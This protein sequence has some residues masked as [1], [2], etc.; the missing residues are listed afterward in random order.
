MGDDRDPPQAPRT[1]THTRI[2]YGLLLLMVVVVVGLQT[3]DVWGQVREGTTGEAAG[4]AGRRGGRISPIVS[5]WNLPTTPHEMLASRVLL[6]NYP[7]IK[8]Q[9]PHTHTHTK[10]HSI[11]TKPPV[12]QSQSRCM[13]IQ[14]TFRSNYCTCTKSTAISKSKFDNSH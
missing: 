14:R 1:T 13:A 11:M 9:H 6:I 10:N 4:V 2:I 3:R 12:G 7:P 5:F 8:A